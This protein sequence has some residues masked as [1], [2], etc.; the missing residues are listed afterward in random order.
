MIRALKRMALPLPLFLALLALP[1]LAEAAGFNGIYHY[2]YYMNDYRE[3]RNIPNAIQ[4]KNGTI[5]FT[6]RS[7]WSGT[8]DQWAASP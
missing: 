2:S 5:S 1:G 3:S 4:I 7:E 8:V 6:E